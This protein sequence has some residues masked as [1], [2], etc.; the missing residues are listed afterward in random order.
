MIAFSYPGHGS[1]AKEANH[2]IYSSARL[3]QPGGS[4]A[5]T[6]AS[7]DV[8]GNPYELFFGLDDGVLLADC[9]LML[10]SDNGDIEIP[11]SAP[12]GD[13]DEK[14][15]EPQ[16]TP[17][18]DETPVPAEE[19]E[20]E[21][22]V[23]RDP[24]T[25][26]YTVGG[27]TYELALLN[28]AYSKDKKAMGIEMVIYGDFRLPFG[29][30]VVNDNDGFMYTEDASISLTTS[31]KII[32]FYFDTKTFPDVVCFGKLNPD[33]YNASEDFALVDPE[34]NSF[35]STSSIHAILGKTNEAN[36][37]VDAEN[38]AEKSTSEQDGKPAEEQ[39]LPE[40]PVESPAQEEPKSGIEADIAAALG[41]YAEETDDIW[42]KAIF[43]AGA[44]DV[45]ADPEEDGKYVFKLRGFDPGIKELGKFSEDNR[46][47]YLSDVFENASK[48]DLE[49]SLVVENGEFSAKSVKSLKSAVSKVADTAKKGFKDNNVLYAVAYDLFYDSFGKNVKKADDIVMASDALISWQLMHYDYLE[50]LSAQQWTAFLYG[51]VKQSLDVSGGPYDI[52]LNCTCIDFNQLVESAKADAYE[53]LKYMDYDNR[54]AGDVLEYRYLVALADNAI[55]M[56]KKGEETYSIQINIDNEPYFSAEYTEHLS[57]YPYEDGLENLKGEVSELPEYAAKHFPSAGWL[58]G[59]KNGTQVKIKAPKDSDPYYVQLRNYHNDEMVAS[60]FVVPGKT[61]VLRVPKGDYY[62][63]MAC[64]TTW[65][66]E[67]LLFGDE[68]QI[69]KSDYLEVLGSNY[70]HT[71]TLRVTE[72]GN[73][74]VFD[75]DEDDLGLDE[76]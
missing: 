66:G 7:G 34:S 47:D 46:Q 19:A 39:Q 33:D 15:P 9:V 51:Q 58:S 17:E 67:K 29:C 16:P 75:A 76:D 64:G 38:D 20:N 72:G 73:L 69:S 3:L 42:Q 63:V 21:Q 1:D 30:A 24:N 6:Y 5:R 59:S 53:E 50:R 18:K 32:T 13:A 45:A 62:I 2:M 41:Q 60:G 28:V 43:E 10:S 11:L 52:K 57:M 37:I 71:I 49:V 35:I 4:I 70:Y 56:R 25:F 23:E 22:V 74:S 65:Y 54:W 31:P 44:K 36:N 26:S 14:Q 48:Y 8:I 61:C 27:E 12:G 40:A 68:T 55:S